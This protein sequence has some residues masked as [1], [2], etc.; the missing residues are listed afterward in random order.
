ALTEFTSFELNLGQYPIIPTI[1]VA[2]V[3]YN[4][5]NQRHRH[6]EFNIEDKV[7]LST[8]NIISPINKQRP[9]KKVVA[10]IQNSPGVPYFTSKTIQSIERFQ[11]TNSLPAIFVPE[12]QQE[13]YKVESILDQK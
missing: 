11:Q 10:K 9:T 12:I 7:L 2:G 3:L 1:L 8:K 6:L 4:Y 5:A 13:E